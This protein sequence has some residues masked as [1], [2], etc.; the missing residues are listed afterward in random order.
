MAKLLKQAGYATGQAGKWRQLGE[1]PSDW[2]FDEYLTDNTAGGWYW[3]TKYNKNAQ[4]LNLPEGTYGPDVIQDFTFDFLRRHKDKPFFFYYAMHLVHKPTLRTPDSVQGA[5]NIDKLYDDNIR[6]MDKQL[7][8]LVA[9][10]ERLGLRQNT[11]V[12]FSGDNGTAAGYPAPVQGRMVNGWKGS[13]LE[14]GSRVPLIASW[15]A[16]TPKGKVLDDIVSF[17]DPYATFAD[18]AEV[19]PPEGFKTDG[20]SFAAQLRGE[21][22]AP[23]AWAFVQLGAHWYVREPGFKLN[24][25]GHLF[26]MADAPFVEKPVD[27]A[28]DTQ[29][30]KAARRRLAA[31]LAE[32]NPAVGKTDRD[33]DAPRKNNRPI[34]SDQRLLSAHGN[35]AIGCHPSNRR[36]LPGSR[37]KS[38]PRSRRKAPKA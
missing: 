35:P 13:M 8:A 9:E 19:K 32:L 15:P 29:Q 1:A 6:Y 31:V 21:A 2:G 22:G 30:S 24:E 17:A 27:P 11:L 16:V 7:G 23:R 4:V 37:W 20:Q 18:L 10:L 28:D 14:G 26:D 33:S 34:A 38:R 3:E 36:A 12:I 25:A 5:K